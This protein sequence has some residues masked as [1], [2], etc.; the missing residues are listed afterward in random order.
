LINIGFLEI[1]KLFPIDYKHIT[2][3]MHDVDV[4]PYPNLSKKDILKKF[5][6]DYSKVIHSVKHIYGFENTAGGIVAILGSD[7][8][9]IKG[10]PN[11]YGWG[12][13]DGFLQN[14][15]LKKSTL[16]LDRNTNHFVSADKQDALLLS[17]TP[18]L[19][20]TNEYRI[21]FYSENKRTADALTLVR[22]TGISSRQAVEDLTSTINGFSKAGLTTSQVVNK[23][24]AVEQD[25]AVS[26]SDLTEALSRTGQAAQEAGVGFDELNALVT[27]A[28]QSTARGGAVI[29]NALKTIFTRLQRTDTLEQLENFNISVRI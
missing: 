29:G 1:K 25:F 14:R 22:L 28:Q 6:I 17:Y 21:C 19:N 10:L 16:E 11:I 18:S 9:L 27:T 23:L 12:F 3:V 5:L 24:A 15:I 13:E 4:I 2:I 26:A 8:E 7:F 20:A